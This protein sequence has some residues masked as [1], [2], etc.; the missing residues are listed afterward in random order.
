MTVRQNL[1]ADVSLVLGS[2][3]QSVTV[4]SAAPLVDTT[5]ATVSGLVNDQRIVDLPLVGRN[6]ID[7]AAVLPGVLNVSASESITY[8][9]SGP[10]M[11]VNG[12]RGNWNFF[13]FDGAYFLNGARNTGLNYP[14]PDAGQEFRMQTANFDAE[15]GLNAGSQMAVVSKTGTN[16]FH[17]DLFEFLRNTVLDMRNFFSPSVPTLIRNQFGG[18]AGGPIKKD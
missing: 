4:T 17:G 1:R 10:T 13:T 12:G 14:P 15:Y 8:V 5:S 3:N 7:L 6:V 2:V 11:N 9:I 18:T 16:M